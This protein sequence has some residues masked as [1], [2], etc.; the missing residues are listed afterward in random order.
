M[1]GIHTFDFWAFYREKL[2]LNS[3]MAD[4]SR[5]KES[6]NGTWHYGI[7]QYDTCLRNRWWT[8]VECDENGRAL[9]LDYSFDE[10]ETT[11]IPSCWNLK[12][13]KLFLYEG[14]MVFTRKFPYE[15]H[16]E[17]ERVF[18]KFGGINYKAAVFVNRT[19][20]GMHEGGSTPFFIEATDV[21]K[22]EDNRI[23]VAVN[24]TRHPANVPMDNTDWFNYGG[25]Y[26]DVELVRLPGSFIKRF[27]VGV[28]PGSDF[29]EIFFKVEIDGKMSGTA[30]LTIPELQ[31]TVVIDIEN[32]CGEHI[33]SPP[34]IDSLELWSPDAPKLYDVEVSFEG[35]KLTDRVGFREIR[36]EGRE[37]LL[38]GKKIFLKG[39]CA[40]EESVENGKAVSQEEIR[41]NYALAKE[42]NC[43]FMRLAHYPHCEYAAK[44]AD[45]VGMLLWEEIPVYWAIE[46]D[47][48]TTYKNAENQLTELITRDINRASVIIWSIGNENP[49]TDERLKFMG[50]LADKARELDGTRPVSAACL[51]DSEALVLTD[52]LIEKI[53]II[54]MNEYYGWY[55]PD[56][57]K[58][59]RV[60]ENSNPEKP[61][62]I[63]EFGAD[64]KGGFMNKQGDRNEMFSE[65]F[66]LRL[67]EKQ[68]ETLFAIDYIKGISPWIF[69]DFRCPRRLHHLQNYYNI[70]GLLSPDKKYKKLAFFAMQKFYEKLLIT[71]M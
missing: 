26:R 66:Q 28:V 38:N 10:W 67:Y 40:H 7:D 14:G 35:D 3:V 32:G 25:I 43:N 11:E 50:S 23:I 21:L 16:S 45:E 27:Q 13:E 55:D 59:P 20:L 6:L 64:C 60:F 31:F 5:K 65:E 49:D 36:V 69:F 33:F 12:S 57:S 19:F 68:I 9:P 51:V 8:E 17:D 18:I 63:S 42:M 30:T 2:I 53:D 48:P 41:E 70:K 24:N 34:T 71:S 62:I 54:G 46:F 47:N 61:V 22:A 56:F 52:R 1:D 37:I 4:Y 58:L 44:I 15:K 29:R 39:V